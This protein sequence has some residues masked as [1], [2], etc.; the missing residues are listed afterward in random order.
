MG[1]R[2]REGELKR[3]IPRWLWVAA[4][5]AWTVVSVVFL[6]LPPPDTPPPF[7]I[8]DKLIHFVLFF[9]IGLA[10]HRGVGRPWHVLAG[11]IVVG[12]VTE[13]VQGMLPWP[14]SPDLA[15]LAADAVGAGVA[16][17]ASV[18]FSPKSSTAAR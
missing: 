9:G 3:I 14:R 10:W 1:G 5:V 12:A 15:D 11:A 6:W 18:R 4:A 16:I 17:F 13:I 2:R 7:P 8:P